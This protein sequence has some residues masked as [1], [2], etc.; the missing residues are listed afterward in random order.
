MAKNWESSAVHISSLADWTRLH[1]M[2]F[3]K[4]AAKGGSISRAEARRAQRGKI[5]R[6]GM[7]GRYLTAKSTENTKG[8]EKDQCDLDAGCTIQRLISNT[9]P[10]RMA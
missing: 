9:A 1:L 3:L 6:V 8:R 4:G 5:R 7:N 2:I 10:R